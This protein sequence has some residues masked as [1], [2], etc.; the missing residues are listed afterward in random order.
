MPK[1][2]FS[3]HLSKYKEVLN[4][5]WSR[6][7][8]GATPWKIKIILSQSTEMLLNQINNTF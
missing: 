3:A 6:G 4:Q 8:A 1:A 7:V 2:R 5:I